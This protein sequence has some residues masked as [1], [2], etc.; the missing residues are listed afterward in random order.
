MT[1]GRVVLSVVVVVVT[2]GAGHEKLSWRPWSWVLLVL[3]CGA[4]AGA[5]ARSLIYSRRQRV[6]L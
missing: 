5:L 1:N 3:D 6:G 2:L 4:T